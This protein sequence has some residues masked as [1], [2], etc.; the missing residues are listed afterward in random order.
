VAR[1]IEPP[2][3]GVGGKLDETGAGQHL[4]HGLAGAERDFASAIAAEDDDLEVR[5]S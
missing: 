2:G 3:Q 1:R 4:G 5:R